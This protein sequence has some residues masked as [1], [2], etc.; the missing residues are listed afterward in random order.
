MIFF[1]FFGGKYCCLVPRPRPVESKVPCLF[2]ETLTDGELLAQF[3]ESL[4]FSPNDKLPS[5]KTLNRRASAY[6]SSFTSLCHFVLIFFSPLEA[7]Q[8]PAT[9][10]FSSLCPELPPSSMFTCLTPIVLQGPSQG[11]SVQEAVSDSLQLCVHLCPSQPSV[12]ALTELCWHGLCVIP[13]FLT[14]SPKAGPHL[15][16]VECLAPSI[17]LGT[18]QASAYEW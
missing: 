16:I 3:M 7:P 2:R 18:E 13:V 12:R 10:V 14:L 11:H 4:S 8:C 6:L 15:S 17:A 9:T 1:F 5:A